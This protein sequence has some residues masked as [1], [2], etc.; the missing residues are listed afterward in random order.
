MKNG[1][2]YPI[3]NQIVRGLRIINVVEYVK[4][5][6]AWGYG[7]FHRRDLN[8]DEIIAA[9]NIGIDLFQLAKWV[10]IV[11]LIIYA[12][13]GTLAALVIYYLIASN[14]FTYFYYHVWG[15]QFKI[16]RDI[17][18]QR[19]RFLNF[20]LSIAFYIFCYAYLYQFQFAD[21][22]VWPESIVD[23]TNALYLSVANA[24]TLT[25][26]GFAPQSQVVRMLFVTELINTFF[27]FTIMVSDALPSLADQD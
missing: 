23:T 27:F 14:L 22:I 5:L 3:A 25:Y 2:I 11:L 1:F 9:K 8:E 19:R 16:R 21:H 10:L 7:K 18:S 26:G 15:S 4:N 12:V 17:G 24:F 6:V 13:S 20:I